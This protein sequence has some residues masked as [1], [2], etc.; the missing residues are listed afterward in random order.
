MCGGSLCDGQRTGGLGP[1]VTPEVW[2]A[3]PTGGGEGSTVSEER[4]APSQTPEPH[5]M[6]GTGSRTL[7]RRQEQLSALVYVLLWSSSSGFEA[8]A[9]TVSQ[10]KVN[11]EALLEI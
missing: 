8:G 2:L 7:G 3:S 4:V 5:R 1:R 6:A 10:P 9:N 11:E